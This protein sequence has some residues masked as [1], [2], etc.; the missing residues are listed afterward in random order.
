M[1]RLREKWSTRWPLLLLGAALLGSQGM[2]AAQEGLAIPAVATEYMQ[3]AATSYDDWC[4][5]RLDAAEEKANRV[6][7][8]SDAEAAARVKAYQTLV[9][10]YLSRDEVG[11]ARR[12]VAKMLEEDPAARF[13]PE[14]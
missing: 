5:L 12:A 3:V 4:Y 7:S 13:S 8:A 10:V 6:V 1:D 2:A 9:L 14:G 11:K